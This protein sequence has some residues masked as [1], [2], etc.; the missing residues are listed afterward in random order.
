MRKDYINL[1]N[2]FSFTS[3]YILLCF[4][5]INMKRIKTFLIPISFKPDGANLCYFKIKL[6]DLTEFSVFNIQV[7]QH[8]NQKIR[9]CGK[10]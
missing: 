2:T 3:K 9:V 8:C 7:T 10:V 4:Y 6:F 1:K 5:K